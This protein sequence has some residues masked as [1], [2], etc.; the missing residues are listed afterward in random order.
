MVL[1]LG[2]A[3]LL[4][5]LYIFLGV[6]LNILVP[7]VSVDVEDRLATI[8]S[9]EYEDEEKDSPSALRLQKLLDKLVEAGE[10]GDREYHVHLV[11]NDMINAFALP[12]GHI[13][14]Y[15]GLLDR[16]RSENELAM[17]LGH[18]LGHFR[19][20]D[21]LRML[22]RGLVL[23][24]FTESLEGREHGLTRMLRT[25]LTDTERHFSERQELEADIWGLNLLV[26]L[27]GHAGGA[28]DFIA[29]EGTQ[30]KE[31]QKPPRF[32]THPYP[33]KRIRS[34]KYLIG[35]KGYVVGKTTPLN[36]EYLE[37]S[38][39][40]TASAGSLSAGQ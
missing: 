19:N 27:Y 40:S 25:L 7:R 28:A 21:Q 4:I 23:V 17:V 38:T 12:G 14:V 1:L 37:R 39:F 20:R 29:R 31:G 13:V 22:G 34:L 11:K 15:S 2:L 9:D 24:F 35:E 32:V 3:G 5:G 16:V 33:L 8:F 10:Q 30:D 26:K 36:P 18:E 6:A